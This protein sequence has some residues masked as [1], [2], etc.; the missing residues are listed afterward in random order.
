MK[1]LWGKKAKENYQ[2]FKKSVLITKQSKKKDNASLN[3]NV[4]R[5]KI[6]FVSPKFYSHS[7]KDSISTLRFFFAQLVI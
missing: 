6:L 7:V 5:G 4:S 2:R 3:L 1:W